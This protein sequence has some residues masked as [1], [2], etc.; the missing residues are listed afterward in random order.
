MWWGCI[1]EKIYM[2]FLRVSIVRIFEIYGFFLKLNMVM[3]LEVYE[4]GCFKDIDE[5]REGKEV[6]VMFCS[7]GSVIRVVMVKVII[8]IRV[9]EK[10]FRIFWNIIII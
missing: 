4:L 9:V 5:F 2:V 10:S 8:W 3:I 6:C 1:F 7:E